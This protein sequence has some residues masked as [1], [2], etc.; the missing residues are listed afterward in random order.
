MQEIVCPRCDEA[1]V[2]YV[3][4]FDFRATRDGKRLRAEIDCTECS[5]QLI[6]TIYLA[7]N[8]GQE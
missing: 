7:I 3:E 1:N 8:Y 2:F 6:L 4:D 5:T